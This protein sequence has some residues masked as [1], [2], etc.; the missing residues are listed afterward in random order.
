M[1]NPFSGIITDAHKEIFTNMIDAVIADLSVTCRIF[2]G[3]SVFT[4]CPNCIMDNINGRSSNTYQA[5]G[6]IPFSFGTCPYCHGVGRIATP[7]NF[8]EFDMYAIYDYKDWFNWQGRKNFPH[9]QEGMVQTISP[10]ARLDE[11]KK[12]KRIIVDTAI[13]SYVKNIF[14]RAGEP[15]FCGFGASSYVFTIWKRVDGVE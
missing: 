14:E 1:S 13:E 12:A 6:T 8:I 2:F 7:D 10:L 4:D 15:E 11:I 5:G 3:D 9:L